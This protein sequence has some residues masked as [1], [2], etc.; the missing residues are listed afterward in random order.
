MEV[1]G[2][3]LVAMEMTQLKDLLVR[4]RARTRRGAMLVQELS[5][6]EAKLRGHL[7]ATSASLASY[8]DNLKQ[9][10]ECAKLSEGESKEL[11]ESLANVVD[12]Q[13][14]VQE[15]LAKMLK[16]WVVKDYRVDN[17]DEKERRSKF[18][19][20]LGRKSKKE[21]EK[22][23]E[24]MLRV[25]VKKAL[26]QER[27]LYQALTLG[28]KELVQGGSALAPALSGAAEAEEALDKAIQPKVVTKESLSMMRRTSLSSMASFSY[29]PGTRWS[30]SDSGVLSEHQGLSGGATPTSGR[31]EVHQSSASRPSSVCQ[32]KSAQKDEEVCYSTIK[33]S[34][35]NEEERRRSPKD[36][37]VRYSTVRRSPSPCFSS[38]RSPSPTLISIQPPMIKDLNSATGTLGREKTQRVSRPPT[39]RCGTSKLD[40][41]GPSGSKLDQVGPWGRSLSN[42]SLFPHP[43]SPTPPVEDHGA[44]MADKRREKRRRNLTQAVSLSS[45]GAEFDEGHCSQNSSLHS[46]VS[47]PESEK[48]HSVEG[49]EVENQSFWGAR[50]SDEFQQAPLLN[51]SILGASVWNA[52]GH[53]EE[54]F[55]DSP[56][57]LPPPPPFLL[58]Q[59]YQGRKPDQLYG[60]FEP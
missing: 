2:K 48:L 42:S 14:K 27:L 57:T 44:T 29:S 23:E 10:A 28:L 3:H 38:V 59:S 47:T 25:L 36:E 9:V 7:S 52:P 12:W 19:C 53:V 18:M 41:V 4:V 15:E 16:G 49:E 39:Q 26:E 5:K 31:T 51:E 35:K 56:S 45:L 60:I 17:F 22:E 32:A 8:L 24:V 54:T 43:C 6:E 13:R 21:D 1:G 20:C 37:E 55:L 11:G 50:N 40:Q 34:S 46:P 30:N 58:D 33:R